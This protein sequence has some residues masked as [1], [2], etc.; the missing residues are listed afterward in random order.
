MEINELEFDRNLLGVNHS[1]GT[2]YVTHEAILGYCQ[3]I[4]ETASIHTNEAAAK[5]AGH[6]ALMAPPAFCSVF[7]RGLDRPD[8]KLNFGQTGFHAGE[9]IDILSPIYSGDTLVANT[10]LKEVYTKTGRS[11]TMV[12]IVWETFFT[13]Q[14]GLVVTAIRESHVRRE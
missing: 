10:S 14:H 3:S 1:A 11:G 2:F 9:A 8:I 6:P 5:A 7:V 12:F 13:N 4:G